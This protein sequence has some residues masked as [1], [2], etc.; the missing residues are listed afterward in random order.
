MT[1][2]AVANIP[3]DWRG[4]GRILDTV[5]VATADLR[6][7]PG[8]RAQVAEGLNRFPVT[9]RR[10]VERRLP[11]RVDHGLHDR[12]LHCQA[13]PDTVLV[14]GPQDVL[15]RASAVPTRPFIPPADET[16]STLREVVVRGTAHLV[17]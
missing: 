13:E 5:R 8:V 12:L 17:T 3:P 7:P 6:P 11:V 15:D 16:G 14:R 10:I 4:E 2:T 9:L 1:V